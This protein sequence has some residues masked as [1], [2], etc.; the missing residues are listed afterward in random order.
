LLVCLLS[1]VPRPQ[2]VGSECIWGA[3]CSYTFTKWLCRHFTLPVFSAFANMGL[4]GEE[5]LHHQQE[6]YLPD[7]LHHGSSLG[8]GLGIRCGHCS[9]GAPITLTHTHRW[10]IY[11]FGCCQLQSQWMCIT[12]AFLGGGCSSGLLFSVHTLHMYV[13]AGGYVTSSHCLKYMRPYLRI[14][15]SIVSPVPLFSLIPFVLILPLVHYAAI[16]LCKLRH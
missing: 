2:E 11:G 15:L 6:I 1:N 13:D 16:V 5:H 14:S 3:I 8:L 12:I 4:H 9:S 10:C 7:F